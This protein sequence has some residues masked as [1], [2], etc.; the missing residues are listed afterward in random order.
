MFPFAD[1]RR[2]TISNVR[3][4]N[5]LCF[6]CR[7]TFEAGRILS[8]CP[9]FLRCESCVNVLGYR[10]LDMPRWPTP[11]NA[12]SRWLRRKLPP[13]P[14]VEKW[15]DQRLQCSFVWCLLLL[16]EMA[17]VR[18]PRSVSSAFHIYIPHL[19]LMTESSKLHSCPQTCLTRF[20]NIWRSNCQIALRAILGS[21]ICFR[22]SRRSDLCKVFVSFEL[23]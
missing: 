7:L 21:R 5:V 17:T 16:V 22:I 14:L 1:G 20:F 4:C 12:I 8:A 6:F 23:L 15:H 13:R 11:N 2:I 18:W 9:A 19:L 3:L 10:E